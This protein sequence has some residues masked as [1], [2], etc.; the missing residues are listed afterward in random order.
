MRMLEGRV[1][2]ITGATSGIGARTAELFVAEG[3]RVVLA[4][5]RVERGERLAAAPGG[6]ASFVRTDVRVEAEVAAMVAHAVDRFG[7]GPGLR[8][9]GAARGVPAGRASGRSSSGCETALRPRAGHRCAG[10]S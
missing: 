5:R 10:G 9:R 8:V 1:A 7:R 6:A 3:A 4:G 2:V